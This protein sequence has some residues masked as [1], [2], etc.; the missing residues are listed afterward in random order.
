MRSTNRQDAAAW[1]LYGF[2]WGF[3]ALVSA[4]VLSVFPGCLLF[5]LYRRKPCGTGWLRLGG[6]AVLAFALTVS[7]WI[8][9]TQIV[10]HGKVLFW[11][12]FGLELWLGNNPEVPWWL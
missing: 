11:S 8:I 6:F 5:A 3:T 9:R 4:A 1:T 10:F 2:V 12:N 7:P